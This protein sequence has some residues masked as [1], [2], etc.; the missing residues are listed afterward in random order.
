MSRER[1]VIVLVF[2]ILNLVFGSLGAVG[3]LC[4]GI[5]I[6]FL[7]VI[8]SNAPAG[9]PV[10]RFPSGFVTLM[11]IA[12]T[13]S[14]IMSGV[15]IIAGV[16]L[17]NMRTWGRKTSVVYSVITIAYSLIYMVINITYVSPT[18]QKW[19]KDFQE[20]VAQATKQKGGQPPPPMYQPT[21]S[22]IFNVVGS[23]VGAILGM[24][25]AVALLVVMF[26]PQVSAAFAGRGVPRPMEWQSEES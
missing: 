25:Y 4:G 19:E 5:A 20:E 1:P 18:I 16:G 2:A 24:A 21:Q 9:T 22:P 14:V 10:P 6:A 17:L 8:F 13:Y 7:G 11:A 15:L 3:S 26:L 12:L 23:V